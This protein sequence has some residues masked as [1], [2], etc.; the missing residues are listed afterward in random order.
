MDERCYVLVKR[1]ADDWLAKM[2]HGKITEGTIRK[3]RWWKRYTHAVS[4][5]VRARVMS[6]DASRITLTHTLRL[7]YV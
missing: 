2:R 4:E 6:D 5:V 3:D 7:F 1:I